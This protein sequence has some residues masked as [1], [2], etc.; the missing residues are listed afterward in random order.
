MKCRNITFRYIGSIS[1]SCYWCWW[2]HHI[3]SSPPLCSKV[4]TVIALTIKCGAHFN[5]ILQIVPELNEFNLK[6]VSLL[7][8]FVILIRVSLVSYFEAQV[9]FRKHWGSFEREISFQAQGRRNWE[10]YIIIA[11]TV[12]VHSLL[13][14]NNNKLASLEATLVRNSAHPLT[15]LLTHRGKV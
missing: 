1:I 15:Y 7:L 4:I 10:S 11:T 13:E 2:H 6:G 12:S 5:L 8:F 3:V 14:T 9:V